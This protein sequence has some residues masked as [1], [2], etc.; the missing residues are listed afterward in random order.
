MALAVLEKVLVDTGPL[1]AILSTQDNHHRQCI[2]TLRHLSPPLLTC[3][4]VL[5]EAAWLLRSYQP[6]LQRLLH[7]FDDGFLQLI[8]LELRSIPEIAKLLKRYRTLGIQLADAALYH[9]A[10]EHDIRTIFTLDRKDFSL[11]RGKK[12]LPFELLPRA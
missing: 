1:I 9:L 11:F 10:V 5:T 4:P 12:G 2:D 3:W 6:A 7:S 8:S